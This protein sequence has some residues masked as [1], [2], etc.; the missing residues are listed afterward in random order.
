M[1]ICSCD[2]ISWADEDSE[3]PTSK[4]YLV[5]FNVGSKALFSKNRDEKRR[6]DGLWFMTSHFDLETKIPICM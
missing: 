4:W 2:Y 5:G 6:A 3:L 1:V